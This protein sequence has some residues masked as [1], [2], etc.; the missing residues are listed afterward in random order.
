MFERPHGFLQSRLIAT[1]FHFDSMM[2]MFHNLL[3]NEPVAFHHCKVHCTICS[4][5]GIG[6]NLI[7]ISIEVIQN[8]V[9]CFVLNI[10]HIT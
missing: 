4:F 1:L 5:P 3:T 2:I 9:C 10:V 8:L 7:Y 6:K